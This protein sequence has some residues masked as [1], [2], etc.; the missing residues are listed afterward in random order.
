MKVGLIFG[1]GQKADGSLLDQTIDRC[2]RGI[3]LYLS[4]CLDIICLTANV[5]VNGISMSEM[6]RSYIVSR[7]VKSR[8]VIVISWGKNTAGEM[9]VFLGLMQLQAQVVF[10]STWY[11][12]PRIIWLALWRIS[13]TRFSVG[14]AWKHTQ[15]RGDFCMEFL[16][17]I[18]AVLRPYSSAKFSHF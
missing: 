14:V 5:D 7:G 11:H 2:D 18:N 3:S 15:F 9:D 16:K 10:I 8:D 13:P 1:Y 4:G 6:M 17:I 12:I